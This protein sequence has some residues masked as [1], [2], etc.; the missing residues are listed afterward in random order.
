MN[1]DE[2]QQQNVQ[3]IVGYAFFACKPERTSFPL[4]LCLAIVHP[5][6]EL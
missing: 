2:H 6:H 5:V 3:M 4:C 1:D